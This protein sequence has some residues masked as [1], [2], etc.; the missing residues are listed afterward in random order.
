MSCFDEVLCVEKFE[1]HVLCSI[2]CVCRVAM[3]LPA[4]ESA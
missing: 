2:A 4:V 1:V 3:L